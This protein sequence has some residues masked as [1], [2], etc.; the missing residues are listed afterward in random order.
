MTRDALERVF[1]TKYGSL[2]A[3]LVRHA[4]GDFEAAEAALSDAFVAA[5]EQEV[6]PDRP[7]A[8]VFA[9]ARRRLVDRARRRGALELPDDLASPPVSEAPDDLVIAREDFPHE[10]DRLRLIFTCCHPALAPEAQVAL[11]LN[12]LSGLS[13]REIAR[14]FLVSD[15]TMSQRLVRAKAKIRRAGIPYRV[16]PGGLLAERLDA[17]LTSVYLIFNEGYSAALGD[18]LVRRELADEGIRLAR[19]LVELLPD[20]PEARGLLAL[21]LLQD[22]RSDARVSPQGELVLLEDQDRSLWNRSKIDEGLV[23]LDRAL[24][25]RRAGPYQIQAAIAAL[26]ARAT[27]AEATDWNEI[28]WLYAELLRRQP[29]PVVALNHAVA[30]AMARGPA[31]GLAL[32]KRLVA[33]G[34]LEGYLYLHSTRAELLVRTEQL[35][36]AR[37]AYRRALELA[38]N[39]L[40]RRFLASRLERLDG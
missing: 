24:A 27:D 14:A 23:E 20:E 15:V 40:E 33:E 3:S 39:A 36:A 16:P 7:A 32:V 21:L 11:T 18:A 26:H 13:A 8:W 38:D 10:D 2:L 5:L 35:G 22:S 4:G 1:R 12:A 19:L 17:V 29:S 25:A 6:L 9:I 37:A 34:A 28:E 31:E 30:V